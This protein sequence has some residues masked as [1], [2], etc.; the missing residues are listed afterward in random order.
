MTA[1]ATGSGEQ[2][3]GHR[4]GPVFTVLRGTSAEE[5]ELKNA[6]TEYSEEYEDMSP[7]T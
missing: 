2:R 7:R 4:K 1:K 3:S 6:K 5:K